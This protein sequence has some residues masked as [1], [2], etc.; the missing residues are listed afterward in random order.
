MNLE[1]I[2]RYC[3]SKPEVTE[4]FP[5]DSSTLVFKIFGKIFLLTDV[6]HF[7]SINVKCDPEKSIELREKFDTIL[8]GFH[9]NKKHWI[10]V[11]SVGPYFNKDIFS[12]IDHSYELVLKKIPAKDRT[13]SQ[14][15]QF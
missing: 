11:K 2:R 6:D 9:M 12:W 8:P 5:F 4:E 13:A 15:F 1:E 3:I 7:E 10:T 14:K